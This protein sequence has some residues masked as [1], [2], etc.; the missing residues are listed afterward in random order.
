VSRLVGSPPG[1][2]GY[3]EGGQLTEAVRR[4]PFSVVLFDEI[5]KAHPDVFNTLLQILEEGRLTDAQGRTVDFKNTVI[6][7]TSNLGTR[8]LHKKSVG[9]HMADQ[10]MN[11]EYMKERVTEELKKH[12]RPEFINRLDEII[13]FHELE[14]DE[15]KEIVDLMLTRVREQLTSQHLDLAL[16][17]DAKE[18]LGRQGYDPEL[19][20]RPLRRAIQRLLEDPLSERVL[21]GEFKAGT[22]ILVSY[23]GENEELTF[24]GITSPDSPPVQLA[25]QE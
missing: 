23:D 1:Y 18:Y 22:T 8:D 19:G 25:G 2:V 9:F 4:K 7:M 12:F 21:L 5:E 13:V 16:T 10:E 14:M 24:E 3:D 6:I 20:A 17:D 11:Y 15:L